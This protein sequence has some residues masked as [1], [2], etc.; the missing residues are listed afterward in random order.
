MKNKKTFPDLSIF[1]LELFNLS[2]NPEDFKK[3]YY[4]NEFKYARFEIIEYVND[5]IE[6]D[7]INFSSIEDLKQII[8]ISSFEYNEKKYNIKNSFQFKNSGKWRA[9]LSFQLERIFKKI[10]FRKIPKLKITLTIKSKLREKSLKL[11]QKLASYDLLNVVN[12]VFFGKYSFLTDKEKLKEDIE[13]YLKSIYL[14]GVQ[15]NINLS[16]RV[17]FITLP[18]TYIPNLE[19]DNL[20]DY[21]YT[22]NFLFN[23]IDSL[24]DIEGEAM[25]MYSI[26]D[27]E[28][29]AITLLE[30]DL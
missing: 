26:D 16:K 17:F 30:E 4:P 5:Q 6:D 8:L 25:L 18:F 28:V 29:L 27:L 21:N 7:E 15:D 14:T 13:K 10:I 20:I 24:F 3:D 1:F 23:A 22:K 9:K 2:L 12:E 11:S 19:L